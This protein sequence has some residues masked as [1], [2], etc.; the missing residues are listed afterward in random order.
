MV[1]QI[2]TLIIALFTLVSLQS[3][4]A[5]PTDVTLDFRIFGVGSDDFK[6]LFFFNGQTYEELTFNRT[7]RST[8]TYRYQGKPTLGLYLQNPDFKAEQPDQPQYIQAGSTNIPNHVST[9][10]IIIAA[11]QENRK[12]A[13]A[14]RRYQAFVM[15]DAKE[16]FGIN[17][18]A[19]LNTTRV[20]LYGKVG[21]ET[22]SLAQGASQQF[23]YTRYS[24]KE[25]G[26]PVSFAFETKFGPRLVMSNDIRLA[27]NR[28]VILILQPPRHQNSTRIETRILSE[29]IYPEEPK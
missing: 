23:D 29:A 26:I 22:L 4:A 19:I 11:E 10:V 27:K 17:A 16:T 8:K 2:T 14:Q 21:E 15:N 25:K 7:S 1:R 13:R 12:V 5:E 6:G 9:S 24:G 20:Q 28:R 18:V 3:N